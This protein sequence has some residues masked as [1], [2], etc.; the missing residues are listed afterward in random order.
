M[1]LLFLKY[2]LLIVDAAAAIYNSLEIKHFQEGD[3]ANVLNGIYY[4]ASAFNSEIKLE[5]NSYDYEE[6]F[7]YM[8]SIS[9]ASLLSSQCNLEQRVAEIVKE[10]LVARLGIIVAVE[11]NGGLELNLPGNEPSQ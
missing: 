8:I 11:K 4:V 3:S 6:E 5:L 1:V 9:I 7:N 2:D 10:T